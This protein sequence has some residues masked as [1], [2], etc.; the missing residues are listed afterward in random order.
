MISIKAITKFDDKFYIAMEFCNG[1]DLLNYLVAKGGYL[2]EEEARFVLRQILSGTRAL[3]EQQKIH[4]DLKLE[5]IMI[6]FPNLTQNA[7]FDK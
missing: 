7:L 1:G 3:N 2:K 5:N 6:H 4:R